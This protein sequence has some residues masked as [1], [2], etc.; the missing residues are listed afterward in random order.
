MSRLQEGGGHT[1]ATPTT[2]LIPELVDICRKHKSPLTG[3]PVQVVAA[4][5]IYR[6]SSL[7]AMLNYVCWSEKTDRLLPTLAVLTAIL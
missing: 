5:G 4:G 6:G 2:L 7:A 1:G 3:E